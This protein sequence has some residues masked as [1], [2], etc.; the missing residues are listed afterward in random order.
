M[1]M[2]CFTALLLSLGAGVTMAQAYPAKP[3]NLIVPF[4]I[5]GP[6]DTLARG[7]SNSM[8]LQLKETLT[9][10]NVAGAGG[11]VA[12]NRVAK[13]NPDGYTL[14]VHHIGMATAPSMYRKLSYN[15]LTDFEFIGEIADVPMTLMAKLALPPDNLTQLIA[16]IKSSNAKLNLGHAGIG[17]ASH[18]C[19]LL[20]QSRVGVEVNSTVFNGTAP[21]L[22]ALMSGQIDL[23]CD[24]TT[25]TTRPIRSGRVKVYGATTQG[26]IAAIDMVPTFAEQGVK[27][28][29]VVVWNGLYA[30]KGTPKPVIDNLVKTLQWTLRD[31]IF[32]DRL[33]N[34]GAEP[35]SK[36]RATPEGLAKK[37]KAE[38]EKWRPVIQKAG[39]QVD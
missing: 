5:G 29:E 38:I 8:A 18:L 3:I 24:Q 22:A 11:T 21:A 6:V 26:R 20:F 12:A 4:A 36:E 28:F 35:V 30:P 9:I 7:L 15:P 23:L 2:R 17:A 31:P 10:E 34:L 32:R 13:A 37:L 1:V 33:A 14:M 27:G 16:Y 39:V 25:N 19:G